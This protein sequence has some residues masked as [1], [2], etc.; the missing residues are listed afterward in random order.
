[1]QIVERFY[2]CLPDFHIKFVCLLLRRPWS[3]T[4]FPEDILAFLFRL[5]FT[6]LRC[7]RITFSTWY[8]HIFQ[9]HLN[10]DL[11][12]TSTQTLNSNYSNGSTPIMGIAR[13]TSFRRNKSF[14]RAPRVRTHHSFHK[15]RKSSFDSPKFEKTKSSLEKISGGS[16]ISSPNEKI[17]N[18]SATKTKNKV[19]SI[20]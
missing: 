1:M 16:E 13:F 17:S 4:V 9:N 7:F 18:A 6:V 15:E 8:N 3:P 19:C 12:T 5:G 10:L 11:D 14:N 20:M 2:Q